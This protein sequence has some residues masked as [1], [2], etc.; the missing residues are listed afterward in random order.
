MKYFHK[1]FVLIILAR[2][3]LPGDKGAKCMKFF[4]AVL[5]IG[6]LVTVQ[7]CVIIMKKPFENHLLTS[8][9]KDPKKTPI[10]IRFPF[11]AGNFWIWTNTW[12]NILY[13]QSIGY[14]SAFPLF[15]F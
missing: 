9:L 10:L 13:K 4:T 12:V 2:F 5:L 14:I 8:L 15:D 6:T 11:I 7:N 3:L 1:I